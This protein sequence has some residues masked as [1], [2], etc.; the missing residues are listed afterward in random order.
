MPNPVQD[1]LKRARQT[2]LLLAQSTI[3]VAG[4][5]VGFLLPPPAGTAEESQIWV[6]FA[7]FVITIVIGM[8][9]LAA[10]RWKRK[11]DAFVW[12]GLSLLCL[13]L[14]TAAFFGYQLFAARWTALYHTEPV[15][16]GSV[17]TD[18]GRTYHEQN[19]RFPPARLIEDF[20][21]QVEKIWTRESIQQR[22]LLLAMM[23]VLAMPLFT[24]CIMSIVQ[25]I[26]CAVA[27]RPSKRRRAGSAA[28]RVST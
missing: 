3:W 9:L 10:L 7:Q 19:P 17:Y 22:R 5:I 18:F 20:A 12:G 26:Q 24:L 27:K 15:L 6:R 28:A 14:G 1:F 13:L 16:I 4:V 11:K 8:V 25:A 21:G 2:W 23:Y